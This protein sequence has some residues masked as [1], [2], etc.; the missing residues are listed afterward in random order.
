MTT[1]ARVIVLAVDPLP[2]LQLLGDAAA[3]VT[4]VES[5]SELPA[6]GAGTVVLAG[7]LDPATTA[8]LAEQT[9]SDPDRVL[10]VSLH[11]PPDLGSV[12]GRVVRVR[13]FGDLPVAELDV[14]EPDDA[15][16]GG[17]APAGGVATS[18]AP[19]VRALAGLLGD[20]TVAAGVRERDRLELELAVRT[21]ELAGLRESAARAEERAV[22]LAQEHRAALDELHAL[23]RAPSPRP[24]GPLAGVRRVPG[25]ALG[26][27]VAAVVG[28]VVLVGLTVLVAQSGRYGLA[29]VAVLTWT[30]ALAG[31][32]SVAR[33]LGSMRETV[34]EEAEADRTD[35]K[36]QVRRILGE[37]ATLTRA[38][39]GLS[40][41]GARTDASLA[42]L[43]LDVTQAR[44]AVTA[45]Q[46]GP[47]PD[48]ATAV[49]RD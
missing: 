44:R 41:A 49:S 14:V 2:V 36:R 47:N 26:G 46:P 4:V 39:D 18:P 11:E 34:A 25:G 15:E 16:P 20:G 45:A 13:W 12:G 22:E 29:A 43:S 28:A 9:R 27:T 17:A 8:L 3:E 30:L 42:R 38:V 10:A 21:Q 33:A 48:P 24:A 5:P 23:H 40:E 35:Q 1:P 31:F 19:V 7:A 6:T 37:L 32:V